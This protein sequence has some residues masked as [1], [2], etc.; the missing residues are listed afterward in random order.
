[1]TFKII[2]NKHMKS[3]VKYLGIIFIAV[4]IVL[5]IFFTEDKKENIIFSET[6]TKT[7]KVVQ[8]TVKFK[9]DINYIVAFSGESEGSGSFS[10]WATIDANIRILTD[11]GTE[12]FNKSVNYTEDKETGGVRRAQ[13]YEEFKYVPKNNETVIITTVLN[14]GDK[15]EVQVFENLDEIT[16]I[17]PGLGIILA[18][19]G[20]V[21]FLRFRNKE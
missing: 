5:F 4:G 3:K 6:N 13:F 8:D 20:G 14:K 21:V 11:K 16:N 10:A 2:K 19:I 17:L 15:T 7:A 18:I 12:L 9:A 1:M